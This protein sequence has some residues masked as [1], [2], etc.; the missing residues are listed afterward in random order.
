[1]FVKWTTLS[2]KWGILTATIW[3]CPLPQGWKHFMVT[4]NWTSQCGTY[5][6]P[7]YQTTYLVPFSS[8][9]K[10]KLNWEQWKISY[11]ENLHLITVRI[12]WIFL[13][14]ACLWWKEMNELLFSFFSGVFLSP[15]LLPPPHTH[16]DTHT[17]RQRQGKYQQKWMWF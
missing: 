7:R 14:C 3:E 8:Y 5:P 12:L 15:R 1:M 4:L 9:K 2:T 10:V 6:S 17:Q 13:L 16:T 11:L